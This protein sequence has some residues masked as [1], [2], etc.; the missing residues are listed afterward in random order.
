M[1]FIIKSK[2]IKISQDLNLYIE[3]RIGKLG[4]FLEDINPELIEAIIEFEKII[5]RQKQGE[6][7][8]AHI[9]LQFPGKF[10]RSEVRGENFFSMI[11]DAKEEL[12]IEIIKHKTKKETLFIRGARSFK[13]LYGIS[14][15]A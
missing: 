10:F 11:D 5:G 15:L 8:E 6:I 13:K 3:K 2:D 12:E 7:F 4:K 9:N 1:K 14:P